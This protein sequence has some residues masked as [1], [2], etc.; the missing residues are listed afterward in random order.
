[1]A[2]QK[3]PPDWKGKN[4]DLIKEACR[5]GESKLAAQVQIATSADQRATVLAGIY[6]AASTGIIGAI[7]ASQDIRSNMPLLVAGAGVATVFLVAAVF[8]I[9]ATLPVNFWTPGNDPCEWYG[10][11]EKGLD[12]ETAIGQQAAFFDEN[13]QENNVVIERNA[14][15]FRWGALLGVGAPVLGCAL[16]GLTCLFSIH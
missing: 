3:T 6:V 1:M 4:L 11:I 12:A 9:L 5:H 7:A 16:A 15:R 14:R 13:I 8:C 10:D 2:T